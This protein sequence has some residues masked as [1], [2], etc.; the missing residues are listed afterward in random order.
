MFFATFEM[1]KKLPKV[2]D[3]PI[4]WAKIHPIGPLWSVTRVTRCVC[5][6]IAQN[7]AQSMLC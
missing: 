3:H 1:S 2:N 7:V 4:Q 5:E 6:K